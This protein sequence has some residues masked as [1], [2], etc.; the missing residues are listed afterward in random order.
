M[1][2][3]YVGLIKVTKYNG[4]CAGAN[5]FYK[6]ISL[7]LGYIPC[8]WWKICWSFITPGVILV[9][10]QQH[11]KFVCFESNNIK[12]LKNGPKLEAKPCL[13]NLISYADRNVLNLMVLRDIS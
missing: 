1:Y 3:K 2:I 9:R 12:S 6:N 5:R 11:A 13:E 4:I 7:M 10:Q 8:M